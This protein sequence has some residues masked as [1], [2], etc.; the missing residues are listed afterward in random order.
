[1]TEAL[2]LELRDL[3]AGHDRHLFPGTDLHNV[4]H[5]LD[6]ALVALLARSRA[7]G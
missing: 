1:V 5:E 7:Q 3:L 6:P 4:D 2:C